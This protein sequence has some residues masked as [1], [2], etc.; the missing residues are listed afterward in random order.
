MFNFKIKLN[1]HLQKPTYCLSNEYILHIF[2]STINWKDH[3]T[4]F[5]ADR[6]INHVDI[7]HIVKEIK[8]FTPLNF[9]L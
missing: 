4:E 5:D 2:S 9:Q 1:I 8:T 6:D 7:V 3:C